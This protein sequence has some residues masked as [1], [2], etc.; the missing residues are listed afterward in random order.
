MVGW[1]VGWLLVYSEMC[2]RRKLTTDW[3]IVGCS[4]HH[5]SKTV[6]KNEQNTAG[7]L[8]LEA[9]RDYRDI[10]SNSIFFL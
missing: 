10:L 1:L 5:Y 4:N 7:T 2:P 3:R 9:V 6:H 8:C